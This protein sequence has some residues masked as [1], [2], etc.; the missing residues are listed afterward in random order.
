MSSSTTKKGVV[1]AKPITLTDL[2]ISVIQ[3]ISSFI[4]PLDRFKL[5]AT[6]RHTNFA[7][8]TW[9]DT[10]IEIR[11]E[12]YGFT[13]TVATSRMSFQFPMGKANKSSFHVK[14][15]T[16]PS[17]RC[18]RI[19]TTQE[20]SS[21]KTLKSFLTKFSN[22]Q[23]L[24]IWDACLTSEFSTILSKFQ[25]IKVLRLWNCSRYFEKKNQSQKLIRSLLSLPNLQS[26]L[27]LDSTAPGSSAASCRAIFSKS[28]ALK[29]QAPIENF[30]ITGMTLPLK[31]LEVIAEN[32]SPTVK[33]L[34]IGCTFGKESKR[35]QYLRALQQMTN[36]ND[37]DLPPFIFHLGELFV[38]D[39]VV[40]KLFTSL[41]LKALGFRHYNSS[42]LFRFIEYQ[43][44]I[45]VRVLRIF[46]NANRIPNFSSIGQ[47]PLE[48][49]KPE[50]KSSVSSRYSILSTSRSS[51]GSNENNNNNSSTTTT[52]TIN[53]GG[54]RRDS[55]GTST[56]AAAAE[57]INN[58]KQQQQP[59]HKSSNVSTLEMRRLTI[60]AIEEAKRRTQR[61][62]RRAYA[63]V[64]VVYTQ[65]SQAGQEV[66][67]RMAEPMRSPHVYSRSAKREMRVIKGDLVRPIPLAS[68]GYESDFEDGLED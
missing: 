54:P 10:S 8:S 20:R 7:L 27:I 28:L 58:P 23:E 51:I 67:G 56:K 34:S 40:Q 53:G 36:V 57:A 37:L 35:L 19:R 12:D 5:Q 47:E 68:L 41:P 29:I 25:S 3:H 50:K 59:Q 6:C 4:P 63:N 15:I 45:K 11:S 32:L 48:A 14:I 52:T 18:Y 1:E 42:V 66:L 22:L 46:H 62:R 44:P 21:A 31:S 13:D 38:P 17:G 39:G 60:F 2:P 64:D 43:L 33:R 24:T 61:L 55:I 16:D 9:P 65:E 30:Q 26:L 49:E